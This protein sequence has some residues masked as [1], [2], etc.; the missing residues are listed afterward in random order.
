M[1]RGGLKC[2]TLSNVPALTAPFIETFALVYL[3]IIFFSKEIKN[4]IQRSQCIA[5]KHLPTLTEEEDWEY[6]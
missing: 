2:L 4:D 1:H 3:F 6:L 5:W